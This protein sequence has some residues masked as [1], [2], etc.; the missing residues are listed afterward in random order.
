MFRDIKTSWYF[1][2]TIYA[3]EQ[4]HLFKPAPYYLGHQS[5]VPDLGCYHVLERTEQAYMLIHNQQGIQLLSNICRHHQAIMLEDR[6]SITKII[7][8]IHRWQ[9]NLNGH[10]TNAPQFSENPCLNLP[11]M[12]FTNW[13]GLIFAE[14]NAILAQLHDIQLPSE[15]SLEHFTYTNSVS[16]T[17][18]FNWKVYVDTYLDDYHIGSFHPG[19]RTLV[20]CSQIK[21]RFSNHY[22]IQTVSN[23]VAYSKH[24]PDSFKQW[25]DAILDINQGVFP[26]YDAIWMLYYP[27]TLIEYFPHLW[28]ITTLKPLG[29]NLTEYHVDFLYDKKILEQFPDYV[30]ISQDALREVSIEDQRICTLINEGKQRLTE[31]NVND[32]GINHVSLEKGIPHFHNYIFTTLSPHIS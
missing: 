22:S 7:C 26:K 2:E 13:K 29:P 31:I 3:L 16:R 18:S 1:D 27:A 21:W 28:I 14:N 9:Y 24:Q 8:P 23:K 10:Q 15:V 19:L 25:Y 5:M 11:T 12:P 20:D 17:Y 6:G 30:A 32:A 4:E